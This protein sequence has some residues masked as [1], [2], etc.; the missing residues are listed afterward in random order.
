[1]RVGRT[2]FLGY[3]PHCLKA[4]EGF[5]IEIETNDMRVHRK[6]KRKPLLDRTM[7]SVVTDTVSNN[8][9]NSAGRREISKACFESLSVRNEVL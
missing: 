5:R 3:L 4:R 2:E 8:S 1:M 6:V 9:S 7:G